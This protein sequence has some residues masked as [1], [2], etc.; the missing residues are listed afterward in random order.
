MEVTKNPSSIPFR[1]TGHSP[2]VHA[3]STLHCTHCHYSYHPWASSTLIPRIPPP[4]AHLQRPPARTRQ[5]E[6]LA[7]LLAAERLRRQA[8][9]TVN[10]N[11]TTPR[12]S[13]SGRSSSTGSGGASSSTTGF[14]DENFGWVPPPETWTQAKWGKDGPAASRVTAEGAIVPM[15][16]I[17]PR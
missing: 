14:N 4:L 11:P 15:V 17:R 10:Q 12:D 7:Q 6:E 3:F 13:D 8:D 9:P 5:K 2:T 1:L 16:R